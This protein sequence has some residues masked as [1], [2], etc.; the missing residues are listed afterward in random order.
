MRRV[1]RTIMAVSTVAVLATACGDDGDDSATDGSAA[2]EAPATDV[3]VLGEDIR[4]DLDEYEAPAGAF[5][6]SFVN[7]GAIPHN[8]VFE[9]VDGAPVAGDLDTFQSPGEEVVYD[10]EA[11]PGDYV[12]FCSVPGHREAGME[13]VLSVE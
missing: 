11:E 9:E 10:L 5:T 12:F 2:D 3:V 13:A 1:I 8:L 4:F 6:L 7:V